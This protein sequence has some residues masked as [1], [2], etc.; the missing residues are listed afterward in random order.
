MS[1]SFSHLIWLIAIL[2]III[3]TATLADKSADREAEKQRRIDELLSSNYPDEIH[4]AEHD[5]GVDIYVWKKG[6]VVYTTERGDSRIDQ[7][8]QATLT[9]EQKLILEME[10]GK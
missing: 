9:P 4:L 2:V 1:I 8:G 7:D 5:G 10:F 6:N 3:P